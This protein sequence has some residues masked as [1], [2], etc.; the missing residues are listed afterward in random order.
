MA[1][2]E[3]TAQCLCHYLFEEEG[4]A[5]RMAREIATLAT[6]CGFEKEITLAWNASAPEW[7]I[8]S[9]GLS[10]EDKCGN[11]KRK[12]VKKVVVM[13]WGCK[14]FDLQVDGNDPRLVCSSCHEGCAN[15]LWIQQVLLE[16]QR[17]EGR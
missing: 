17:N 15:C 11:K 1:L 3:Q 6:F 8:A 7:L 16:I 12:A 5:T 10:L 14:D 4:S 2:F 13:N 9:P